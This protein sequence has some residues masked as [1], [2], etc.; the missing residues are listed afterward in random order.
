MATAENKL[1]LFDL[2]AG[3]KKT[4]LMGVFVAKIIGIYLYFYFSLEF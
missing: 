1:L 2:V 4:P 3:Y